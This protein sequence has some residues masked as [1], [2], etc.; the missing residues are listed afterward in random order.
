MIEA[1]TTRALPV[2]V[3]RR[4]RRQLFIDK[5]ALNSQRRLFFTAFSTDRSLPWA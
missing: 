2:L 1:V 4:I 5:S 3:E